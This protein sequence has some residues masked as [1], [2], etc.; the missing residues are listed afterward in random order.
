MI[1]DSMIQLEE[2]TKKVIDEL[3]LLKKLQGLDTRLFI[4]K[5]DK[6]E[7]PH[8]IEALLF[9]LK[10]EKD[11][12]EERRSEYER[13][14]KLKKEKETT[15][16]DSLER[17]KKLKA[18]ITEI[19]TNKEYQAHLKEIELA[20]KENRDI[21]DEILSLMEKIEDSYKLVEIEEKRY[22]EVVRRFEEDRRNYE[23]KEKRIDKEI[24]ELKEKREIIV[25]S[26]QKENYDNYSK[27]LRVGK[28]LAIVPIKE[29]S[30]SGC[31]MSLPPQVVND[32][33][34]NEEII[35]CSNCHRAL[36]YE[37]IEGL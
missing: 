24:E 7:I 28:G 22:N 23:E 5:D 4:L 32:V 21:E 25:P 1:N 2:K 35:E 18:R 19:K 11:K 17:L 31:H 13:F 12:I 14:K 15:L 27:I 29:G 8:S 37:G 20:E 3:R 6:V 36:Y 9:S 33:R 30:C 16:D 34:K 26:I 10:R